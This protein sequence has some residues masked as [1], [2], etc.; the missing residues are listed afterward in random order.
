[1]KLY[2]NYVL[3]KYLHKVFFSKVGCILKMSTFNYG[4]FS[5]FYA[6]NKNVNRKKNVSKITYLPRR[7]LVRLSFCPSSSSS[8]SISGSTMWHLSSGTL[9]K[10]H[11][12]S[13]EQRQPKVGRV[14]H[15]IG[16]EHVHALH[17][18]SL[19]ERFRKYRGTTL[20]PPFIIGL[21]ERNI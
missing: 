10:E 4:S 17:D 21:T 20:P 15:E 12:L 6:F 14:Q 5:G 3:S 9:I 13:C 19:Q 11:I 1:M 16:H 7:R 8:S 2:S 18:D